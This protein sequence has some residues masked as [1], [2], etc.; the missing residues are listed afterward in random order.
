MPPGDDDR[1]ARDCLDELTP[2]RAAGE[3][4]LDRVGGRARTSPRW[5]RVFERLGVPD[6]YDA[7]A[8]DLSPGLGPVGVKLADRRRP[9]PHSRLPK[10][11]ESPEPPRPKQPEGRPQAVRLAQPP[12]PAAPEPPPPPTKPAPRALVPNPGDPAGDEPVLPE[13][14]R[15]V[16]ILPTPH[17]AKKRSSSG[18]VRLGPRA[19][20]TGPR[21]KEVP[22]PVEAV[23][24]A[25]SVDAA[26]KEEPVVQRAPPGPDLGLDDLFGFSGGGGRLKRKKD[27][28]DKG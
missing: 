18:R 28:D 26:P 9:A 4:L 17:M 21:I 20:T 2:R 7:D 14:P 6:P 5:A 11:H 22:K 15:E 8:P 10:H 3:G 12:K 16:P 27:D 24:G 23:V 19:R 1:K 25:E 13:R